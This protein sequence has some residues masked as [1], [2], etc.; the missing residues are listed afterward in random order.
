[1]KIY[2]FNPENG[3]YLGEDYSEEYGEPEGDGVTTIEPPPCGCD[4]V[5]VFDPSVRL[6]RVV[7]VGLLKPASLGGNNH[8]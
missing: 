4:D 6:W 1:M 2:L 3:V 5:A 7:G 8:E